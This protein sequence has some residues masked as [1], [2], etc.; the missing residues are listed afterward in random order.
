MVEIIIGAF[1]VIGAFVFWRDFT[2]SWN[3]EFME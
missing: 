2:D 1:A 3:H